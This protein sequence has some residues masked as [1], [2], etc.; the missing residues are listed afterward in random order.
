MGATMLKD[1][2][3]MRVIDDALQQLAAKATVAKD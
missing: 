3:I 2:R 1:W